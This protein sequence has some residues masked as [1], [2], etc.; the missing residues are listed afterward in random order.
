MANKITTVVDFVTDKA[1]TSLKGLKQNIADAEGAGGKL[2]AGFSGVSSAI[3][4]NAGALALGAGGALVAFGIKAV[5]AFED[6]S[7]AAIDLSTS[8]GLAI[9]DASRWIAVGDDYQV[10]AEALAT[11]LGKVSKTIDDTKWK[12]YGIDTRDASGQARDAN[13]ILLDTFDMLSKVTNKT[14]Q[15]AIGQK[16]FGKGYQSLTPILGHTRQEYEKMLGAVEKGQVITEKEAEK[17]EAMRLAEDDLHDALQD[18]TLAIGGVVA[19]AAPFISG[20]AKMVLK[21]TEFKDVLEGLKGPGGTSIL[22]D[23]SDSLGVFGKIG[24]AF[25]DLKDR[26]GEV[27]K[28]G[29]FSTTEQQ[30]A[31]DWADHIKNLV[32]PS[33]D[34]MDRK[35]KTLASGSLG[36]V[37]T[38][39]EEAAQAAADYA[40][41]VDKTNREVQADIG[42]MQAKWDALTGDLDR[43]QSW[44]NIQQQVEDVKQAFIDAGTA[45]KDHGPGSPE[46]I[47]A[48]QDAALKVIDLKQSVIDYGKEVDGLPPEKVTELLAEIDQG[49]FDATLQEMD[50]QLLNHTFRINA[51]LDNIVVDGETHAAGSSGTLHQI[52]LN[53]SGVIRAAEGGIFPAKP[54][55]YNVNLAEGGKD[56]AVIPLDGKHGLGG[57][58][59]HV[60]ANIYLPV[61]SNGD[62]VV[63]AIRKFEARNG[64]GWRS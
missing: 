25:G 48:S 31:Q 39:E 55:G 23:T 50:R 8:T 49:N 62:D 4:A 1:G 15:A 42:A 24:D 16:L 58:V 60:T 22:G 21:V 38:A 33:I 18:V 29:P 37:T 41:Q 56:E 11:G 46:A 45:A 32:V 20:V 51:H 9:E 26:F 30:K 27:I 47:K 2:K 13:D 34:D 52:G 36:D 5:G 61:G 6:T 53:N 28:Y 19:E 43:Q 64:A 3:Q 44:I 40:A 17:A 12:Q 57:G 14:E 10:S 7:K 54:G 59:T 35:F 63:R